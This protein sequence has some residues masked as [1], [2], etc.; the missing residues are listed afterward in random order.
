MVWDLR[1]EDSWDQRHGPSLV[2]LFSS[3]NFSEYPLVAVFQLWPGGMA[4][5]QHD[6]QKM[7]GVQEDKM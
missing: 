6:I 3:F 1:K 7:A 5:A 2:L 4:V